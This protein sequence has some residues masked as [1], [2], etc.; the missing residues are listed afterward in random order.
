VSSV[1]FVRFFVNLDNLLVRFPKSFSLRWSKQSIACN[2][3]FSSSVDKS[4]ALRAE[5]QSTAPSHLIRGERKKITVGAEETKHHR[6][7][8]TG[9]S[10]SILSRDGV[11]R[12]FTELYFSLDVPGWSAP[13]SQP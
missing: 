4:K 7:T 5:A 1:G 2:T 6:D 8:L 11:T 9:T 10:I 13:T 12:L 3:L